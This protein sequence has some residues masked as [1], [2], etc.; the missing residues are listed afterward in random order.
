MMKGMFDGLPAPY[1]RACA[2]AFATRADAENEIK[3]FVCEHG[4]TKFY[5]LVHGEGISWLKLPNKREIMVVMAMLSLGLV[6]KASTKEFTD[7][8]RS[9]ATSTS[10]TLK[11][12]NPRGA[13]FSMYPRSNYTRYILIFYYIQYYE[14]QLLNRPEP[15]FVTNYSIFLNL[16]S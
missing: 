13:L 2:T 14:Q 9:A 7:L 6:Y 11:L 10:T 5:D 16:C 3:E 8:L 12:L 1:I 15:Q 4:V